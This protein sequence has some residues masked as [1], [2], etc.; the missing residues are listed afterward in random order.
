MKIWFAAALTVAVAVLSSPAYA[1]MT[2][3]SQ[4]GSMELQLPNGWHEGKPEGPLAKIVA[5]DGRGSR[6][7]VRVYPKED[8]KDVK[9][10]ANFTIA[11]L[12][13]LDSDGLKTEDIQVSGKPGVRLNVT[14]TQASGMRAGYVVT[15]FEGDGVYIN[16]TG[17]SDASNFAKEAQILAGFA[18]Q[19]K[20]A[21]VAAPNS[22]APKPQAPAPK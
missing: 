19:L 15:V 20:V 9:T 13:L 8:F 16:V 11:K 18:S 22:A 10:A 17:R 5:A 3:K 4:D 7:V 6:V 2:V 21:P 14:G 1:D 12:K